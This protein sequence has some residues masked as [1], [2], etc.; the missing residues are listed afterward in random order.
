MEGAR[1]MHASNGLTVPAAGDRRGGDQQRGFSL[2]EI[3]V[4]LAII[5]ILAAV[6]Y[7]N[8]QDAARRSKRSDG[9]SILLEMV[10]R[11]EQYHLDN[12]TYAANLADLGY[13]TGNS[14]EGHYV[15][16]ITAADATDFTLSAAAQGDQVNDK[17]AGTICT[18]LTIDATGTRT[19][20][21]CW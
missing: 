17:Q 6:A 7:P 18:P 5:G 12:K 13:S 14:V 21:D 10:N 3:L 20:A 2:I 8:Y 4:V 15:V 1:V 11:Q 19:P 16:T 9:K